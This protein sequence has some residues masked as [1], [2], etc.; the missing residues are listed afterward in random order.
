MFKMA[1]NLAI[2]SNSHQVF[3]NLLQQFI[4]Q[5]TLSLSAQD[6]DL[7]EEFL[8]I[9]IRTKFR[10]DQERKTSGNVLYVSHG[11]MTREI[12]LQKIKNKIKKIFR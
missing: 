2:A 1:L 11:I 9:K 6:D 10:K 7:T 5:Q 4:E 3:E 8:E 12:A